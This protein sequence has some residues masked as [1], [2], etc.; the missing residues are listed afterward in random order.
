MTSRGFD[1]LTRPGNVLFGKYRVERVL[2][3]G[4]MGVVLLATHIGLEQPVALK[5]IRPGTMEAGEAATRL[6]REARAVARLTSQHIVRVFD[7]GCAEGAPF[8][9]M[10]Y[11]SGRD[12]AA[13]L[14]VERRLPVEVAALHIMQACSAL[15]Q[16]HAAGVVHRDLKPANL[17]LTHGEGGV[18]LI[19]VLDFGIA[20]CGAADADATRLT[21]PGTLVGSPAY[22]SPE[23]VRGG[24]L[25]ARSDVWSLG[26]VLYELIAGHPPWSGQSFSQLCVQIAIEEPAP[27]A[28]VPDELWRVLRACLDKQPALRPAS[29]VVLAHALRPFAGARVGQIGSASAPDWQ[30]PPSTTLRHAAAQITA[31]VAPPRARGRAVL[32]MLATAAV[33]AVVLSWMRSGQPP[34]PAPA[35]APVT[36]AAPPDAGVAAP[37]AAP[38]IAA[39]DAVAAI[40]AIDAALPEPAVSVDAAPE[41]AP[42]LPKPRR[43]RRPRDPL[44]ERE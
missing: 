21:R 9:V 14:Q 12:L 41:A 22:M 42:P 8:V 28:G 19:K 29:V 10:E 5:L 37:D 17:F 34:P 39:I 43:S 40:A 3:E 32:G 35:L 13:V 27:I 44:E 31:A 24:A 18:P 4:G 26:V 1:E 20:T 7:V 23:Q 25:D 30:A 15:A 36:A 38:A 2:G 33:C 6:L 11:L 16:A